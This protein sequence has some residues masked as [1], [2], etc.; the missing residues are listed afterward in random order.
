M[1]EIEEI[2]PLREKYR[3][4]VTAN[5]YG[6]FFV[7]KKR[8]GIRINHMA[9]VSWRHGWRIDCNNNEITSVIEPSEWHYDVHLVTNEEEAEIVNSQSIGRAIA[10]GL[11]YA[12]VLR[13]EGKIKRRRD[14][15]LVM[16]PH[17][18]NEQYSFEGT[19][20]ENIKKLSEKFS[21]VCVCINDVDYRKGD[22]NR[23][24]EKLGLDYVRGAISN[25]KNALYRMRNL[26]EYFEYVTT[27]VLGSH[28]AYAAATG[29][30][31]SVFMQED[32]CYRLNDYSKHPWFWHALWYKSLATKLKILEHENYIEKWPWLY[33]E[34]YNAIE[35]I[36][37]G[38]EQIGYSNIKSSEDLKCTIGLTNKTVMSGTKAL[39][40]KLKQKLILLIINRNL[41]LLGFLS[42]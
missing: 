2:L 39:L 9:S 27:P 28:I 3:L 34:P 32:K 29:A 30:K 36:D 13:E 26:F 19:Y 42:E 37:W 4:L 7:I 31:V 16:P 11:P 14:S 22:M 20:F 12:Y 35:N 23:V 17:G 40:R 6:A 8:Y 38:L 1:N 21:Y 24:C 5:L 25:D 33:V 15:L 41:K 18:I 10:V